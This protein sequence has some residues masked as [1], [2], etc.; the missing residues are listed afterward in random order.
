LPQVIT[1]LYY[2]FLKL[3]CRQ[4]ILW[5]KTRGIKVCSESSYVKQGRG[6][7]FAASYNF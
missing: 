3:K 7:K 6:G 5:F 2:R 1:D 4:T